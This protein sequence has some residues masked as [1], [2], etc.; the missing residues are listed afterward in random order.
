[1][2]FS[3]L[4]KVKK[5]IYDQLHICKLV[6]VKL[7]FCL[8]GQLYWLLNSEELEYL[9]YFPLSPP[10]KCSG[11]PP[12]LGLFYC[13][14]SNWSI[15]LPYIKYFEHYSENSPNISQGYLY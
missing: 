6:K 10:L 2:Q 13:P 12:A 4:K 3:I 9:L 1:M 7:N 5:D 11:L 8:S 14:H 15:L